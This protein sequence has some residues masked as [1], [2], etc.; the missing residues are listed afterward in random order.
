M[1]ELPITGSGTLN[2]DMPSVGAGGSYTNADITVDAQGRVTSASNG[3]SG[4]SGITIQE[5]GS[6]L[7]TAAI[8]I[9]FCRCWCY[10][11]WN[12]CN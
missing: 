4:I 5:E 10:C 9:K 7:S 8:N 3:S 1:V 6:S 11:F 12:W 2:I